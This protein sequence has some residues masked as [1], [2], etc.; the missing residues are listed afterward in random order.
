MVIT[1][2][3]SGLPLGHHVGAFKHPNCRDIRCANS[4]DVRYMS[5]QLLQCMGST[6]LPAEARCNW[7]LAREIRALEAKL[8]AHGHNRIAGVLEDYYDRS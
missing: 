6:P 4:S 3:D 7:P 8:I 5:D 1:L 2:P